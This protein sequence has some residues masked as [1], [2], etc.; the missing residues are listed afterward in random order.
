MII[1][2]DW[3]MKQ[4]KRKRARFEEIHQT[5]Q[6]ILRDLKEEKL[7]QNKEKGIYNGNA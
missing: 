1:N 7:K 2:K 5:N 3:S 6:Q 4:Y